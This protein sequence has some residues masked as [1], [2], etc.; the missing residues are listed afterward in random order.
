MDTGTYGSLGAEKPAKTR[1]VAR[2]EQGAHPRLQSIGGEETIRGAREQLDLDRLEPG[3]PHPVE[4]ILP[5]DPGVTVRGEPVL[6]KPGGV[7][8]A[9]RVRGTG[10]A[11]AAVGVDHGEPVLL[12]A[13][14][15]LAERAAILAHIRQRVVAQ[16]EVEARIHESEHRRVR[17]HE[18][19]GCAKAP[20]VA[21]P[22]HVHRDAARQYEQVRPDDVI[23]AEARRTDLQH[24]VLGREP[25]SDPV[26]HEPV[27]RTR[28]RLRSAMGA[29][30]GA[31]RDAIGL[32]AGHRPRAD[33]AGGFDEADRNPFGLRTS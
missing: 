22:P 7:L 16:D 20:V 23:G 5:V 19:T 14:R 31:R 6:A 27:Q 12:E 29:A 2:C 9:E 26:A 18:S 11:G 32:E 4:E 33:P 15:D 3:V 8:P 21:Q 25:R 30:P 13:A 17:R 24:P 28:A 1:R 10:R